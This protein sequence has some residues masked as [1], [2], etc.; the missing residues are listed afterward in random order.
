M[1]DKLRQIV[2][3]CRETGK[4]AGI[5]GFAPKAMAKWAREGYQLFTLGYVIGGNVNNLQPRIE[6]IKSVIG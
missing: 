3:I 2:R 6:E 4:T 1:E 5:G